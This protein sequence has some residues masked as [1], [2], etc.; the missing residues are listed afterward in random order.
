MERVAGA[1]ISWGICEVPGWGLQLPVDRVLS[2]M[3][4]LGLAATEVGSAGWLPT[5]APELTDVVSGYGLRVLA[6]FVPLVLHDPA[7][8]EAELASAAE[9]AELLSAAG[10]THYVTCPISDHNAWRRPALSDADWDHLCTALDRV[11]AIAADHGLVQVL[12]PHVDSLVEQAAELERVLAGTTTM[13]CLDTGHLAI[14]GADPVDVARRHA[15]RVGLVH[16]KD[17]R[18]TV[19]ERLVNHELP[20]MQAVQAGVFSPLGQGDVP[21]D[22]VILTLED[23]GYTGW[24]VLEQDVALTGDE[25]TGPGPIAD[26]RAS[27]TYLHDLAGRVD[28]AP[29]A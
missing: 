14:G 15:A 27:L 19:A 8:L 9:T 24:Y 3:R 13:F 20:L 22:K 6:A 25:P 17:V 28:G 21:I 10:A 18:L 11:G 1:P 5:T 16:L 29:P 26:V 7:R 2:E 12:H 4:E 23:A